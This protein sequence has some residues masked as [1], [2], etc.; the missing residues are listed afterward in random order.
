MRRRGG[1]SS[2]RKGVVG[3][4]L[5]FCGNQMSMY[6]GWQLGCCTLSDV[7]PECTRDARLL[8]RAGFPSSSRCFL[9]GNLLD[10]R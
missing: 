10:Y 3:R 1:A 5:S 2:R 7:K 8:L 9:A 6:S 4:L